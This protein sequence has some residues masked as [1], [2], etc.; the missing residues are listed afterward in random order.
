LCGNPYASALDSYAFINANIDSITGTLYFWEHYS[1]NNSHVLA[2]YQGG[3]ATRNLVGGAAPVAPAGISV[4]GSSNRIPGRYIP[5]GQG[6]IL[7]GSDT[8][9]TINFDNSQRAFIKEYDETNPNPLFRKSASAIAE[10]V[11]NNKN[12]V[13]PSKTE[14]PKIRLGFIAA[15]DLH[16][17][18][19]LG[20]MD[21]NATSGIDTGYDAKMI[22]V[23][24]N[25]MYFL[26]SDAKL[27]IQGDGYFNTSNVYPLGVITAVEGKVKF[28][29]DN[30]EEF[31]S[32]QSIYIFDLY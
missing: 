4:L 5:V 27:V 31:D 30:L 11:F 19:L 2:Q 22:D 12:D 13:I 25:D 15:N 10:N 32:N 3:Y 7:Y 8:G 14:F 18:L 16:R 17:Q 26:N 29:I 1:T 24:P 28:N 6:F 20:F 9:G 23:Q 21:K